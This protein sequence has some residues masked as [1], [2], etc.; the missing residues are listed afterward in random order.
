VEVKLKGMGVKG[1]KGTSE[2][3][4]WNRLRPKL[5]CGAKERERK[6]QLK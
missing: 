5:D 4:L 1:W 6:L 2:R 3:K